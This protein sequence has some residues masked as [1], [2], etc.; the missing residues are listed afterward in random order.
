MNEVERIADQVAAGYRDGAWEIALH[1]VFWHDAVRRRIGGETVDYR[2]E[3]GWPT[4]GEP[5]GA[6]W[7]AALEGLDEAHRALVDAVRALTPDKLDQVVAGGSFTV[8]FMLHG[9]PQHDLY[10]GGQ[11]MLLRKSIRAAPQ[12]GGIR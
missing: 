12:I 9:V 3:E 10:H 5:T 4:P 7:H 11:V 8:Y 6:N 2:F 1:L